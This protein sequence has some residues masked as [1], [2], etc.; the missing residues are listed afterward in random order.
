[1]HSFKQLTKQTAR[2][3]A[4]CAALTVWGGAT[5]AA[6][7]KPAPRLEQLKKTKLAVDTSKQ[8]QIWA[9]VMKTLGPFDQKA[10]CWSL[11]TRSRTGDDDPHSRRRSLHAQAKAHG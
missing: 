1:M 10:N 4:L 3:I 2:A 7:E 9:A 5:H 6:A 8:Q 11:E